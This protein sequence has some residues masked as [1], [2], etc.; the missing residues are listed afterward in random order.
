MLFRSQFNFKYSQTVFNAIF[1][2]DIKRI[3]KNAI[4]N[5]CYL[6]NIDMRNSIFYCIPDAFFNTVYDNKINIEGSLMLSPFSAQLLTAILSSEIVEND[7]LSTIIVKYFNNLQISQDDIDE[8]K[9]ISM[10]NIVEIYY[11]LPCVIFILEETIKHIMSVKAR[12]EE[13][14]SELQS[15]S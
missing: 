6:E 13:H 2:K 7:I 12:S 11:Y 14:T 10:N 5:R 15:H 9:Y 1:E 3:K 4:L 8:L